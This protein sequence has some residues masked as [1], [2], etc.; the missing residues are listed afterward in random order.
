[1]VKAVAMSLISEEMRQASVIV[2]SC[3]KKL[4]KLAVVLIFKGVLQMGI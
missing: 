1:M 2:F 3:L 4:I